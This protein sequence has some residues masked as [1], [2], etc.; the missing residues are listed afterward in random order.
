MVRRLAQREG[1]ALAFGLHGRVC[2]GCEWRE[3]RVSGRTSCHFS[4]EAELEWRRQTSLPGENVSPN[5]FRQTSSASPPSPAASS[6]AGADC[7]N[8]LS[9]CE[10]HCL[11]PKNYSEDSAVVLFKLA[12]TLTWPLRSLPL[13]FQTPSSPSQ[14]VLFTI[15]SI[16]FD[17]NV[18][19][20]P[21]L[22]TWLTGPRGISGMDCCLAAG[23][24]R[25]ESL[26]FSVPVSC[27][28]VYHG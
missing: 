19:V 25:F 24:I 23:N 27:F 3:L 8:P 28:T 17:I 1:L 20:N 6:S 14:N 10:P 4:C 5:L 21:S 11:S 16:D 22:K 26:C 7:G 18:L 13:R 15:I 9:S 12:V 2:Y